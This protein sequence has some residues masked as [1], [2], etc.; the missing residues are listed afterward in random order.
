MKRTFM[1]N[2]AVELLRYILTCAEE[3]YLAQ[4]PCAYINNGRWT[5]RLRNI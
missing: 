1:R 5:E 3:Y 4:S 2:Q